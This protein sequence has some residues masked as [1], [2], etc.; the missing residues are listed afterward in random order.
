MRFHTCDE[1]GWVD[2]GLVT[3]RVGDDG[4]GLGCQVKVD[5][6]VMRCIASTRRLEG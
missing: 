6:W 4:A 3:H 5:P 2:W 1:H